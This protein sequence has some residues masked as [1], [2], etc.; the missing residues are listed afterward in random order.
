MEVDLIGTSNGSY[1]SQTLSTGEVSIGGDIVFVGGSIT[2]KT[3]WIQNDTGVVANVV[4][5]NN[6]SPV[7]IEVSGTT[8]EIRDQFDAVVLVN[9]LTRI[10]N[11][12]TLESISNNILS[13]RFD[14]PADF[15]GE[16][17]VYWQTQTARFTAN[18]LH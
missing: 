14:I 4:V 13:Y 12:D 1:F 5:A 16:Y 9:N 10:D 2:P 18:G 11:L 3:T 15:D 6:G 17:R 8:I 7:P